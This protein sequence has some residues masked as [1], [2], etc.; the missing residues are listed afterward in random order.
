MKRK[1]LVWILCAA[2][3]AALCFP[4]S[5]ARVTAN[6]AIGTLEALGLVRGSGNGFEPERSATRAEAVV[7]LLRLLGREQTALDAALHSDFEDAGWADAYLAYAQREGLVHGISDTV[8]GSGNA[9]AARDYVTMTL[10]ALGY[11]DG[12]DFTWGEC[13]AFSDDIG[14]THGEYGPEGDFLREDMALVSY[15]A[16]TLKMKDSDLRL[17]ESL[18]LRGAV[19]AEALKQTR[20]AGAANAGKTVYSAAEIHEMSASAVFFVEVYRTEEDLENGRPGATGSGFLVAPDGVAIMSYHE[21]DGFEFANATLTDGR[22]FAIDEVLFYDPQRDA[23]VVRLSKTDAEG[24]AI[25]FFPYL[26]VGDS[27]AVGTGDVVYTESN[28]LGLIDSISGGLV[29][30]RSRVVDD[31]AYPCIQITA[32]ISSGSSGGALL[33]AHGEAIGI[34]FASYTRGQSLN[35]AVP[36][37]CVRDVDRNGAGISV[38]EVCGIENEKKAAAVI[39]AETTEITLQ[40]EEQIELVIATD[41]PGQAGLQY[42]IN[43]TGVVTCEWGDYLTKQSVVLTLTG[44][45]EGSTTVDITFAE[46]YG[47]EEAVLTLTVTVTA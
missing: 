45:A 14:L 25:R 46:G 28:P 9:V 32:P 10:R 40:P 39:T 31:P 7:M 18:Y 19:S 26:D 17:I 35:L 16:L 27:D 13:L 42:H 23:A 21:L 38:A 24:N 1:I 20:L 44:V 47:N 43:E 12:A 37:N 22:T 3:F 15:T 34:I 5:A 30:N 33:N 8:F 11:A 2:M 41:C 4:V 36:V 6:E 29:S